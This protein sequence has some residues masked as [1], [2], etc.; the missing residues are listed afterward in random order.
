MAV[1]AMDKI[2]ILG[3]KKD[4]QQVLAFLQE[5]GLVQIDEVRS[6]QDGEADLNLETLAKKDHDNDYIVAQLDFAIKLL[7]DHAP[8]RPIWA[9][10][11]S[12]SFESAMGTIQSFNYE[13]I[14]KECQ[15]LE[16][17][18]VADQN[19][20]TAL[21]TE[22]KLLS[23]WKQLP[24]DLHIPRE[25]ETTRIHIGSIP[26]GE[27]D[28]LKAELAKMSDLTSVQKVAEDETSIFAVFVVSKK[29][30]D[31]AKLLFGQY[32]FQEV[33]LPIHEMS[34]TERLEKIATR[35]AELAE[36]MEK[37]DEKFKSL[38]KSFENLQIVHDVF[39]WQ[40]DETRIHEKLKGTDFSFVVEG[41][42][43][44]LDRKK[45]E[46]G[47][48]EIAVTA[49]ENIKAEEGEEAPIYLH[50]KRSVWPFE[51][52]TRLYGFPTASEVDPTPFLAIFF[53]VFFGLCLTDAGYGLS[54]F[55]IMFALLKFFKLPEESKG[56]IKLL[57]IGGLVTI[58]A[59]FFFGGYF[60][61]TAEQ[62]PAF[63]LAADGVSFKGQLINAA[64]GTGPLTFLI[65]ALGLGI[66]HVLF[67]KVVDG[68]WKIKQK[69]YLDAALDSFL[70]IYYI[71]ALLGFGLAASG[72]LI[73][74]EYAGIMKW[75][76]LGGTAA[77][78]L[79]QGRKQKGFFAK[80]GIG[81]LSLY[82]L[83]G[84][85]GD[86]LSYS[87]IMAL[88]LGTGIIAFAMN[89]IAGLAYEM[90]PYVGFIFAGLVLV[91]G[92]VMNLVLS[93]LG[94]FIHSARLQFVEFFSK[95]MEGGGTEFKP[96]K[97]NCK[98]IIIQ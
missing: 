2:Q 27:Y 61:L 8:K 74:A 57:M 20:I 36:T 93:A 71:L 76:V 18:F 10:K 90:I 33:E 62:A 82:G 39:V 85:M 23:T 26:K 4:L 34:V 43:A 66:I 12:L 45:L 3:L 95:F 41:W 64:A 88:G 37:H 7:K 9:G 94:A 63:M 70:W 50:N 32:K 24:F 48:K 29:H 59:G 22:I 91:F 47:L 49:V 92:H 87:R 38:A 13:G 5:G 17:S 89:T 14:I 11:P 40:Q 67:G 65:L 1:L 51:S 21:Q 28:S 96:F 16:E 86:I 42:M 30:A 68:Y 69:Q 78:V 52:V 80:A 60:G 81:V 35:L 75:C 58:V 77:M 84:Y 98:Y 6:D 46:E 83:V 56:L 15:S 54:L 19:E 55:V 31:E 44:K 79:T 53:I 72:T 73:P 25:T 97:R